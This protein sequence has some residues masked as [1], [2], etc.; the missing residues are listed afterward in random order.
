MLLLEAGTSVKLLMNGGVPEPPGLG[1]HANSAGNAAGAAATSRARYAA[2]AGVSSP[3]PPPPPPGPRPASAYTGD[4]SPSPSSPPPPP[5]PPPPHTPRGATP[6]KSVARRAEAMGLVVGAFEDAV[7][8]PRADLSG[9]NRGLNGGGGGGGGTMSVASSTTQSQRPFHFRSVS[10]GAHHTVGVTISGRVY[11]WGRNTHGQLGVGDRR[12]RAC[13]V[14]VTGCLA[15]KR[16]IMAAAGWADTSVL[17]ED[18]QVYRW[19]RAAVLESAQAAHAKEQ[20]EVAHLDATAAAA[21]DS[22]S[23]SGSESD[24]G[25]ASGDGA[26]AVAAN[27]DAPANA[28]APSDDDELCVVWEHRDCPCAPALC[29]VCSVPVPVPVPVPAPVTLSLSL[30][31]A[32]Y[33]R[34]L[35]CCCVCA[36]LAA[37]LLLWSPSRPRCE[38]SPV[39]RRP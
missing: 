19:G 36:C 16:A 21:R 14:L 20:A 7:A 38:N 17:T 22:D 6:P 9:R 10:C 18:Q 8:T 26:G 12:P 25:S 24:A 27:G 35:H 1:G 11:T 15:G 13:P 33:S 23:D 30:M 2:T 28:D 29:A 37:D 5:P 4:A 39:S 31:F 34:G 3:P 32:H